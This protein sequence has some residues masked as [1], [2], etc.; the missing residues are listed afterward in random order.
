MLSPFG[1]DRF[2]MLTV[3]AM[4]EG[5]LGGIKHTYTHLIRILMLVG[6]NAIQ[7]LN[8]RYANH[9]IRVPTIGV[10][11]NT[12]SQLSASANLR[13]LYYTKIP[14]QYIRPVPACSPR[15]G[16]YVAVIDAMF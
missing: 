9:N 14:S 5:E 1:F 10:L 16:G 15:L 8:A 12:M 4:H 6:S 7:T 11:N 2:S 3:D 13:P